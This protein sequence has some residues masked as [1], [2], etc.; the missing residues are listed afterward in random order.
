MIRHIRDLRVVENPAWTRL[1]K[2]GQW[3]PRE[4][5]DRAKLY[6]MTTFDMPNE[7]GSTAT[8]QQ[9]NVKPRSNNVPQNVRDLRFSKNPARIERQ[10]WGNV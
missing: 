5:R 1:A 6:R 10:S 7:R 3:V 4:F 2:L 9:K 8:P